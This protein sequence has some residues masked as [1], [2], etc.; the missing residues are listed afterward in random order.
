MIAFIS[1]MQKS[2]TSFCVEIQRICI[3]GFVAKVK[4]IP[5][6]QM[7]YPTSKLMMHFGF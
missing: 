7:A 2:I 5:Y 3:D 4:L 6:C 1:N